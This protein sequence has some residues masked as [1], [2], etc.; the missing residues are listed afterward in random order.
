MIEAQRGA[1]NITIAIPTELDLVGGC[2]SE[3]HPICKE[4][5]AALVMQ[6][7]WERWPEADIQMEVTHQEEG[8]HHLNGQH[9][10][11]VA[12]IVS[13]LFGEVAGGEHREVLYFLKEAK[14]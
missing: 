3:C 5:F 11:E 13:D 6:R 14:V 8:W 7:V 12:T 10:A 2:G 9:S 4:R 1:V